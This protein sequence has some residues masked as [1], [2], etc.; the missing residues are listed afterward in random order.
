V[1]VIGL[2]GGFGSGKS[3][4]AG[5]LRELGA[6]V[7]DADKV[8]HQLYQPGTPAFDDVVAAFGSEIVGRN[9]EIDRKKLGQKVFGNP[10]ALGRLNAILHPRISDRV[11]ETLEAWR[12]EGAKVAVVEAALLLEAGWGPMVDQVWVTVA[13][14]EK[15]RE[16]LL[17][18]RDL[19]EAD[20]VARLACQMPSEERART[21]DVV[22]D[23]NGTLEQLREQ[24]NEQWRRL[25]A[26]EE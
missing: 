3:T 16:R 7:I 8:A 22:I 10:Q 21:A 2:T 23:T 1:I 11:K 25:V 13:S 15:A 12:R 26:A 6:R 24:V 14:E 9:G 5:M 18:A 20:I 19:S 17:A 4:V